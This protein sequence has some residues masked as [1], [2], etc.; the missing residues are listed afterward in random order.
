MH[1]KD[2]DRLIFLALSNI[3]KKL[4][5]AFHPFPGLLLA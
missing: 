5:F 2:A 4:I 1:G 3:F